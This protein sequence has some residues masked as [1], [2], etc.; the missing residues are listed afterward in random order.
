M[1][2][3]NTNN[4]INCVYEGTCKIKMVVHSDNSKCD[5]TV[6]NIRSP[7]ITKNEEQGLKLSKVINATNY[8]NT[9]KLVVNLDGKG[10]GEAGSLNRGDAIWVFEKYTNGYVRVQYGDN[11]N[12]YVES[13]YLADNKEKTVK[14]ETK[15]SSSSSTSSKSNSSSSSSSGSNNKSSVD[16]GNIQEL[17]E[18]RWVDVNGSLNIRSDASTSTSVI[19][20]LTR[21][22]KILTY[23]KDSN[24]WSK[25][26]SGSIIGY[27]N[28]NYLRDYDTNP[29]STNSS[30]NND[31]SEIIAW[32]DDN[33]T[34]TA[35]ANIYSKRNTSSRDY[36]VR[37]LKPGTVV[38]VV[39][40]YKDGWVYVLTPARGY[41]YSGNLK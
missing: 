13:K 6:L 4:I 29:K 27:V 37:Q 14:K 33:R 18:Y 17:N 38:H 36:L 31:V 21:G 3:S 28:S 15:S 2:N 12:L 5:E 25:I 32:I 40:K 35:R 9:D 22:A 39:N 10:D 19:G 7:Y 41:M 8:V 16:R 26:K 20:S 1:E 30:S 23:D 11:P 24:G 34:T